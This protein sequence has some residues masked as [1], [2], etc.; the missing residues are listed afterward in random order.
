MAERHPEEDLLMVEQQDLRHQGE[1]Y[2]NW[3]ATG[4]KVVAHYREFRYTEATEPSG[5]A[6]V[7]AR[8][9]H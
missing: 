7:M 1:R 2:P 8:P 6:K 9:C 4:Y 5:P 3:G